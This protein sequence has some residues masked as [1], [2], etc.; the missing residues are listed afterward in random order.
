MGSRL[1][2]VVHLLLRSFYVSDVRLAVKPPGSGF[3]VTS[4][5]RSAHHPS[6]ITFFAPSRSRK[7]IL[8]NL[9]I[10]N[11]K[12]RMENYLEHADPHGS[13]FSILNSVSRF[14]FFQP[15]TM[16]T[17]TR[18]CGASTTYS[19]FSP[20]ISKA[21]SR[22]VHSSG[23]TGQAAGPFAL[24]ESSPTISKPVLARFSREIL[25]VMSLQ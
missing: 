7:I 17:A 12:L 25:W 11:G 8:G 10:E 16:L 1:L 21:S 14:K 15:I 19:L 5:S 2:P 22:I 3:S 24:C 18:Y 23:K 4:K 20:K 13:R 9:G 6:T